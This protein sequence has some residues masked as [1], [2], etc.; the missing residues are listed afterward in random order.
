MNLLVTRVDLVRGSL[1]TIV[2]YNVDVKVLL[3]LRATNGSPLRVTLRPL[4][5]LEAVD[6]I[7]P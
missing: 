6:V 4:D 2:L 1:V 3:A 7:Q 5:V